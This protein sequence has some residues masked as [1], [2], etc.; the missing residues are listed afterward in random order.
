MTEDYCRRATQDYYSDS[1]IISAAMATSDDPCAGLSYAT[2]GSIKSTQPILQ[3]IA[4]PTRPS[5]GAW[6][7]VDDQTLMQARAQGINWGPIQQTYFPNKTPNACRKRHERL[8]ERKNI[9]D[10]DTIK[11][12][13]IARTYMGMR[14]EIW[15]PLA[16]HTGEKWHVVE[17]KCMSNGLKNIQTAA[18]S[19]TRRELM[20][21]GMGQA[22]PA[23][24][25]ALEPHTNDSSL[26]IDELETEYDA[27]GVSSIL[28]SSVG[29]SITV[30]QA[31]Y[32]HQQYY[33][34]QRV[35]SMKTE[36]DA[37]IN[38][39]NTSANKEDTYQEDTY[40]EDKA[41]NDQNHSNTK[42]TSQERVI[43][44]EYDKANKSDPAQPGAQ[45]W[46]DSCK[47]FGTSVAT[48]TLVPR[49]ANSANSRNTSQVKANPKRKLGNEGFDDEQSNEQEKKRTKPDPPMPDNTLKNCQKFPSI[50]PDYSCSVEQ[51]STNNPILLDELRSAALQEEIKRRATALIS[52]AIE[53]LQAQ[54][55]DEAL[56][57]IQDSQ[58]AVADEFKN[59]G[60]ASF[61]SCD[62]GQE[63]LYSLGNLSPPRD[64][65]LSAI[66]SDW[67]NQ[68]VDLLK[69][70]EYSSLDWFANFWDPS[71]PIGLSTSDISSTRLSNGSSCSCVGSCICFTVASQQP[72]TP[73]LSQI[74]DSASSSQDS[75]VLNLLQS[76]TRSVLALEERMKEKK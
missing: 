48:R 7:P 18:R 64:S 49:S 67:D 44:S 4:M 20:N 27:D 50:K 54:L 35:P 47:E 26:N 39:P 29:T 68:I 36:I 66:T 14:K 11:L 31:Q 8:M 63:S 15:G 76:L 41:R 69:S 1:V 23:G 28:G 70:T 13:N 75:S 25:Y 56:N 30:P 40:Q 55:L 9:D 21:D 46:N 19:A 42:D 59:S 57:M 10:W 71:M 73:P 24:V 52:S 2:G 33:H 45:A 38:R 5:S 12:E 37:I 74:A 32:H 22:I 43:T 62:I 6:T 51:S 34:S 53:P 3:Q 60:S 17:Q 72:R 58:K 61:I 65:T 16:A